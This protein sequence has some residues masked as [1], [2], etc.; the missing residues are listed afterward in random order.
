MCGIFGYGPDGMQTCA[1]CPIQ[2]KTGLASCDGTPYWEWFDAVDQ[3]DEVTEEVCA[4][5]MLAF[6]IKIDEEITWTDDEAE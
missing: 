3:D 2:Q 5:A 1:G 4:R 6:L